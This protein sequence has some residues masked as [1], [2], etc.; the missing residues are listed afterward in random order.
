MIYLLETFCIACQVKLRKEENIKHV[1]W[2]TEEAIHVFSF[3]WSI[4]KYKAKLKFDVQ[5]SIHSKTVLV[6]PWTLWLSLIDIK[7]KINNF[8]LFNFIEVHL[9]LGQSHL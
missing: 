8:L 9:L 3:F 2:H 1:K 7:L 5:I 4:H 6:C